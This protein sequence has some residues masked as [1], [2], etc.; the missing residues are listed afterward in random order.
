MGYK[1]LPAKL[2]WALCLLF[3]GG[4]TRWG[5]ELLLLW[6]SLR[7]KPGPRGPSI[8]QNKTTPRSYLIGNATLQ[9]Y[10][11]SASEPPP[12]LLVCKWTKPGKRALHSVSVLW[13]SLDPSFLEAIQAQ[14]TR[15]WVVDKNLFPGGTRNLNLSQ[16]LD[17]F[18]SLPLPSEFLWNAFP[19]VQIKHSSTLTL[20]LPIMAVQD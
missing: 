2:R 18:P 13:S 1:L 16:A 6:Q 17:P 9:V 5:T 12:S 7:T 15:G 8:L 20:L 10:V 14:E 11:E 19:S 3:K 4:I